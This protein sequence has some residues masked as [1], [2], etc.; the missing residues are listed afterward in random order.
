MEQQLWPFAD[1]ASSARMPANKL[2]LCFSAFA[3]I[4]LGMLHRVGL[5]GTDLATARI[6]TVRSR[7]LKR[8]GRIGVTVR[9][10][11]LSFAAA[12]PFRQV[13]M[14]ALANLREA[15]VRAPP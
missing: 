15:P 3:G 8:A 13:F 2:R 14:Y 12:F 6:D 4:L 7:L 10:V 11:R 5:R 1:R 9:R